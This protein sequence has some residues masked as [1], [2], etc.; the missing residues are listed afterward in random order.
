M[1][2]LIKHLMNRYPMIFNP[3]WSL[4]YSLIVPR[5][6]RY[7][8]TE[9]ADR[10]YAFQTI[11][12]ENHWGSSETRSGRGSIPAADLRLCRNVL[13]HLPNREIETVLSNFA[14]SEVPLL[15]TTT[16]EFPQE[17]SDIRA[18]GFRF[19]NLRLPPFALPRPIAKSA[20]FI[21]PEPPRY[22]GLWC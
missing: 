10:L 11:Y 5:R 21:A 4:A 9:L 3:L 1:K 8:G 16:C 12:K 19:I 20:D 17:N 13:F 7:L 18:G 22:L 2:L 6:E 15:L 14:K